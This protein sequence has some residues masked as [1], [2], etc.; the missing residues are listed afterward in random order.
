MTAIGS[1]VYLP[2]RFPLLL[3]PY[4]LSAEEELDSTTEKKIIQCSRR[5][6]FI[7]IKGQEQVNCKR[8]GAQGKEAQRH[9]NRNKYVTIA[10]ELQLQLR[11]SPKKSFSGLQRDSNL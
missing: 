4:R 8:S 6:I 11:S 5:L 3:T 1:L 7:Q 9:K 2:G 10:V